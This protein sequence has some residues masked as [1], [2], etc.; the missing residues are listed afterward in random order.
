[1]GRYSEINSRFILDRMKETH[2]E[3]HLYID[4]LT[5]LADIIVRGG[6]KGSGDGRVYRE[7][8]EEYPVE[9]EALH[10]E[11]DE[12]KVISSED[13]NSKKKAHQEKLRHEAQRYLEGLH[14]K[15]ELGRHEWLELG[16]LP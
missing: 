16:G 2:W 9:A 11:I 1:M 7:F 12:G 10:L 5:L 4:H 14:R 15:E 6:P 13:F 8:T 3:D